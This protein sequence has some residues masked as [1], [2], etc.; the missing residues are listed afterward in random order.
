MIIP[1]D[2][3]AILIQGT[4]ET[5]TLAG[6]SCM[7]GVLLGILLFLAWDQ[8]KYLF[9]KNFVMNFCL[10]IRSLPEILIL[11]LIYFGCGAILSTIFNDEI[12]IPS[13]LAGTI[14]LSIIFA[15]YATKIFQS[16]SLQIVKGEIEISQILGLTKFQTFYHIIWPKL[17]NYAL[18]GLGNL[19]L[20]LL[21]D[22]VLISLIGGYDLMSR[23]QIIIHNTQEPFKY[24]ILISSVYLSLTLISEQ[25]LKKA[26]TYD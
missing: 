8:S 1:Y 26:K 20:I 23:A 25:F 10:I 21:K 13:F 15:A 24:Y 12:E 17:L 5:L 22:T 9:I 3:A 7:L 18:P 16:A 14:S 2:Y 19:W 6:V 4:F 11:F